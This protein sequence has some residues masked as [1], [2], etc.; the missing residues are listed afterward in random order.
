MELLR[1][2]ERSSGQLISQVKSGY[3]IH[4]NFKRRC[5]SISLVTGLGRG[6]FPLTCLGV[7]IFYGRVKS[8]NFEYLV[9]LQR[10]L[11]GW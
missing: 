5:A 8:I 7:S 4:D 3:Y 9:N 11:E 10:T 6:S 2:Y 1:A